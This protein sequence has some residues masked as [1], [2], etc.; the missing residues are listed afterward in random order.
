MPHNFS[1]ERLAS[2]FDRTIKLQTAGISRA[3]V[4]FSGGVD[5]SLI[6][7]AVSNELERTE[8]FVAGT[9]ESNDISFA[10][11]VAPELGLQLHKIYSL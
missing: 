8:L 11:R 6:A 4:L 5:S 7:K 1:Q 9:P 3:A 10:E 2:E